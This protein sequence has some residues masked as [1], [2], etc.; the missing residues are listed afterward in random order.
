MITTQKKMLVQFETGFFEFGIAP[1]KK[2]RTGLLSIGSQ[3]TLEA[4]LPQH[5]AAL[6][7]SLSKFH[8]L[9]MPHEK[10]SSV[11]ASFGFVFFANYIKHLKK[12]FIAMHMQ[13]YHEK[14]QKTSN[15]Q[16]KQN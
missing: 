10:C 7:T 14:K 13:E 16:E 5:R 15:K 12:F 11:S 3:T 6:A 1:R 2:S 9:F 4:N 8:P